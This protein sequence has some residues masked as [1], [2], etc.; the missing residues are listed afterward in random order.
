MRVLVAGV[1]SDIG[2]AIAAQH[3]ARGDEV[4]TTSRN[5]KGKHFLEITNPYTWPK[6]GKQVFDTIYYTI[7]ISDYK[8]SRAEV[9]HINAFASVDF[10]NYLVPWASPGAKMVVLTSEWGSIRGCDGWNNQT[11]RMTKAALNMGVATLHKRHPY[12]H[13]VLMQPGFTKTK[14]TANVKGV[15]MLTTDTSAAGIIASA[16]AVTEKFSFIDYTGKPLEF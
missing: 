10:L 13:W 3:A 5:G 7:G 2:A 8:N 11:Y 6:F 4:T 14:M 12:L 9:M 15:K 16:S 1:D